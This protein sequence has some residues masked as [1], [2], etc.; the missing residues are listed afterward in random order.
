MRHGLPPSIMSVQ[1][2]FQIQYN[3]QEIIM[4]GRAANATIRRQPHFTI[5]RLKGYR[6]VDMRPQHCRVRSARG[7]TMANLTHGKVGCVYAA[8]LLMQHKN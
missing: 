4:N 6:Q 3:D 8:L 2:M 5:L 1:G 7:V